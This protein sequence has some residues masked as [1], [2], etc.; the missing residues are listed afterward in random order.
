MMDRFREM[1]G[2][3]SFFQVFEQAER[4][5]HE[6]GR[7]IFL[8]KQGKYVE[9]QFLAGRMGEEGVVHGKLINDY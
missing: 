7:R 8:L 5:D 4:R 6:F 2:R 1:S 9:G 3:R